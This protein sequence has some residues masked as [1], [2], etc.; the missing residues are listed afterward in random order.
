MEKQLI[1]K[2]QKKAKEPKIK[3]SIK[4]GIMAVILISIFC[5]YDFLFYNI[6]FS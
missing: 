3:P 1:K 4:M 6:I 5:T 2:K